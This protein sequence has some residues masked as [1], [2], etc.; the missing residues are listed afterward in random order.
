MAKTFNVAFSGSFKVVLDSETVEHLDETF[1][2]Y[3]KR[4]HADPFALTGAE[5]HVLCVALSE[6]P[7]EAAK[8]LISIGLKSALKESLLEDGAVRKVAPIQV[9]VNG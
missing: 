1:V 6:G 3:A 9:R 4:Y 8:A 7:D 5:R 2:S